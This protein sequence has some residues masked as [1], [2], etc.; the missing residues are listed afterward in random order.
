MKYISLDL[1]PEKLFVRVLMV[2]FGF[3]C[4]F[5]SGWWALFIIR[6]PDSQNGFWAATIFL[7]LFGL[8]Q[9]YSGL[10]KAEKYIT[11]D[12]DKLTIRQHSFLMAKEFSPLTLDHI[13]I[14]RMD[15]LFILKNDSKY[16]LKL[17]LKYPDLGESIRDE[18]TIFANENNLRI[19]YNYN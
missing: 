10:G 4:L 14:R 3:M 2:I 18:I 9:I 15:I 11:I 12:N 8:Y 7:V 17:G 6:N 13:E 5:T 16:R 1:R 19:E